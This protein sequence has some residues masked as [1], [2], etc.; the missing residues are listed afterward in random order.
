MNPNISKSNVDRQVIPL[1]DKQRILDLSGFNLSLPAVGI[2]DEP[3]R[4]Y[5]ANVQWAKIIEGFIDWLA[6]IAVWKDAED[7]SY[8]GIQEILKFLEGVDCDMPIDCE[9]IEACIAGSPTIGAIENSQATGYNPANATIPVNTGKNSAILAD[10][11]YTPV[12][13]CDDSD[14]DALWSAVNGIIDFWHS[15]NQLFLSSFDGVNSLQSVINMMLDFQPIYAVM[16]S[17]IKSLFA[18]WLIFQAKNAYETQVNLQTLY[19]LKCEIFCDAVGAGCSADVQT[20]IDT[21]LDYGLTF[22]L[23]DSIEDLYTELTT[24]APANAKEWFAAVGSLQVVLALLGE[25]SVNVVGMQ[26]F[27]SAAEAAAAQPSNSWKA[28]CPTCGGTTVWVAVFDFRGDYV[29]ADPNEIVYRMPFNWEQWGANSPNTLEQKLG[30][31]IEV[32][33]PSASTAAR[34]M[35]P[36]FETVRFESIQYRGWDFGSGGAAIGISSGGA[37]IHN[38]ALPAFPTDSPVFVGGIT[39]TDLMIV[40]ANN[41][42]TAW[43][44]VIEWIKISPPNPPFVPFDQPPIPI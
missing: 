10:L 7:E 44:A 4:C 5:R 12:S 23:G 28:Y 15:R 16:A 32:N 1:D 17:G 19:E 36:F 20:I 35:I 42:G 24:L 30:W 34:W 18:S 21:I 26:S 40:L 37:A 33:H 29:S 11:I 9:E 39:M 2:Y 8:I 22:E 6:E 3:T 38:W 43:T 41:V 31:G 27:V 14:K 13:A 25:K